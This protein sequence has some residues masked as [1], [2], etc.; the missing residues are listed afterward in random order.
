MKKKEGRPEDPWKCVM[1]DC[2]NISSF[3]ENSSRLINS[4]EGTLLSLHPIIPQIDR[5]P[6]RTR[7]CSFVCFFERRKR[8]SETAFCFIPLFYYFHNFFSFLGG[9]RF[10]TVEESNS[11]TQTQ[12]VEDDLSPPSAP[13]SSSF[14]FPSSSLV[15]LVL[16]KERKTERGGKWGRRRGWRETNRGE[17]LFGN[18]VKWMNKYG[19]LC[20]ERSGGQYYNICFSAIWRLIIAGVAHFSVSH[21]LIRT[22]WRQILPPESCYGDDWRF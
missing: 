4:Q 18:V 20:K 22:L 19:A 6:A 3:P 7:L 16:W 9:G 11:K 5:R 8:E 1:N 2:S 17:V 21:C 14:L 10:I 15:P 12:K 13:L